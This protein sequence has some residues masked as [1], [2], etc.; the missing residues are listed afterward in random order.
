MN[1]GTINFLYFYQFLIA[2]FVYS[3]L[4]NEI[5]SNKQNFPA[6][7]AN[8]RYLDIFPITKHNFTTSVLKSKDPWVLIFH[9]GSLIRGWKA[10]SVSARGIV[11]TGMIDVREEVDL[12]KYLVGI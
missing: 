12:L 9:D 2:V 10:L 3:V 4:G 5:N 8:E 11:W 1:I 6:F 7:T